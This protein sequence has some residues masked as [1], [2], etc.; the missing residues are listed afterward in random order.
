MTEEQIIF[1]QGIRTEHAS[2]LVVVTR[3]ACI[4]YLVLKDA[5]KRVCSYIVNARRKPKKKKNENKYSYNVRY[6]FTTAKVTLVANTEEGYKEPV[7]RAETT[8]IDTTV[9]MPVA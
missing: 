9:T 5:T 6:Y 8:V 1:L 4:L 7:K 3:T 2:Y